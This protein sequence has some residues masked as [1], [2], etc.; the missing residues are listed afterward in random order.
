MNR[1]NYVAKE[2]ETGQIIKG[3]IQAENEHA[4]GK[5]LVERGLI[6]QAIRDAGLNSWFASITNR[7]TA[8]DKILFTRQFATLINAGVP[9]DQSLRTVSEQTI[10]KPMRAIIE[11]VHVAVEGGTPIADAMAGHPRVFSNVYVALIRSGEMSGTLDLAMQ[12][13]ANQLEKDAEVLSKIRGALMYP[14]I[15]LI[16]IALVMGFMLFTIVPQV[17]GLYTDLGQP[18]PQLTAIMLRVANFMMN[19][20]WVIVLVVIAMFGGGVQFFRTKRGIKFR[21]TFYLNIPA[22]KELFLRLYWGR[23]CRTTQIL[24]NTGVPL[25]EALRIS[26]DAVAN[27]TIEYSLNEA[28][29]LVEGGKPL[30]DSLKMQP[31]VMPIVPQMAAIGEQSGKMDELLGKAAQILESELDEKV[32]TISTLIEPV[33]MVVLAIAAGGMIAAILFPIYQ[34]VGGI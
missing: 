31:Y 27:V 26:T 16:V 6:P 20:W 23:F 22:F 34:L 15:V 2:P 10:S 4:A 11:D 30:S 8:K 5:L 12:R 9:L 28:I 32:R 24:L 25:V 14:V 33:L 21:D 18:L 3:A 13:L 7:V 17:E 29:M 1:F 19:Y